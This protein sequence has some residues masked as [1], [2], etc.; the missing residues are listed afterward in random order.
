[1]D[2]PKYTVSRYRFRTAVFDNVAERRS[3]YIIWRHLKAIV[4]LYVPLRRVR[5]E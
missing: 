4:G 5:V 1:M 3:A 2:L